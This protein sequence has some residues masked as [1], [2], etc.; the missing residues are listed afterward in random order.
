MPLFKLLELL[1]V[2][3]QTKLSISEVNKLKDICKITENSN[4]R[5]V[6]LTAEV[7]S[8]PTPSIAKVSFF[9]LLTNKTCYD[10]FCEGHSALLFSALS[11]W[12]GK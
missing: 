4:E 3:Y 9:L 5:I 7:R 6:S 2:R 8:S 11:K 1:E 10:C 12:R